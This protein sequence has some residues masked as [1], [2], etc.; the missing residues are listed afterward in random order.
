MVNDENFG[1][2]KK[3]EIKGDSVGVVSLKQFLERNGLGQAK[4]ILGNFEIDD[5]FGKTSNL[6]FDD[7]DYVSPFVQNLK[8]SDLINSFEASDIRNSI[9]FDTMDQLTQ[10]E[11]PISMDPETGE[12]YY[13]IVDNAGM[14]EKKYLQ[15]GEM[16]NSAVSIIQDMIPNPTFDI[17]GGGDLKKAVEQ[18]AIYKI[19]VLNLICRGAYYERIASLLKGYDFERLEENERTFTVLLD[20]IVQDAPSIVNYILRACN[21]K[22]SVAVLKKDS[23]FLGLLSIKENQAVM[24][25][26]LDI[27]QLKLKTDVIIASKHTKAERQVEREKYQKGVKALLDEH[28]DGSTIYM[29]KKLTTDAIPPYKYIILTEKAKQLADEIFLK[30]NLSDLSLYNKIKRQIKRRALREYLA[31]Y[32]LQ[33]LKHYKETGEVSLTF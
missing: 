21:N 26:Q 33:L 3:E 25:L 18:K 9:S 5:Q 19:V 8:D 29:I 27:T 6:D 32:K 7:S 10:A 4:E 20:E 17:T 2:E 31:D 12:V 24:A 23:Q 28:P 15:L 14:K 30:E 16:N 22:L 1:N 11:C 13:V